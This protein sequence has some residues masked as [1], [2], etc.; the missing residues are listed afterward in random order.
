MV[1]SIFWDHDALAIFPT[2]DTEDWTGACHM[3]IDVFR[4]IVVPDNHI[5]IMLSA[6][7]DLDVAPKISFLEILPAGVV[8]NR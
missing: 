3:N 5:P 2:T 4:V 8:L 6:Q 1:S 7:P